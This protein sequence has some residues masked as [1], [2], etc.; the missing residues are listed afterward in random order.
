MTIKKSLGKFGSRFAFEFFL[1]TMHDSMIQGLSKY[2]SSI[3]VE[4]IPS[5]VSKGQFPDTEHLDFT[6]ASE[7]IEH[8]EKISLVRLMEFIAEACPDLAKAIQSQGGAGVEYMVKLRAHLLNNLRQP[9]GGKEF[10]AKEDTVLAHC[11]RCGNKWP[12]KREEAASISKCPFCG[13][14]EE[15]KEHPGEEE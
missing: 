3:K 15:K 10:K 4:D 9:A 13:D 11:D 12:V 7:N 14:G 6:V 2:L 8:I 1:E 5:M